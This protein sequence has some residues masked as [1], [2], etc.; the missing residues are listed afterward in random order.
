MAS[1]PQRRLIFARAK[2]CGIEEPRLRVLLREVTGQESTAAIPA[3][4]VDSLIA[5]I[6]TESV[7]F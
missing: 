7:A 5:A 6:E 4:L 3:G 2:A 1:E